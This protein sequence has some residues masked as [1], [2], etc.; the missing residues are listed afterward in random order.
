MTKRPKCLGDTKPV[1]EMSPQTLMDNG[2]RQIENGN[3]VR[4]ASPCGY[5]F[6]NPRPCRHGKHE[7]NTTYS[8]PRGSRAPGDY[9]DTHNGR[10][11]TQPHVKAKK[12]LRQNYVIEPPEYCLKER[13]KGDGKSKGKECNSSDD[14]DEYSKGKRKGKNGYYFSD[15]DDEYSKGK[16]KKGYDSDDDDCWK[17]GKGKMKGDSPPKGT[18]S[19]GGV[20]YS[21]PDGGFGYR[22][23]NGAFFERDGKGDDRYEF[24]DGHGW[25]RSKGDG[26][27]HHFSPSRS[28]SPTRC[29]SGSSH[30]D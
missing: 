14:A 21:L 27:K 12:E 9:Q 7:Y 28:D 25:T 2:F 8:A 29:S 15:D 3:F 24:P 26:M 10:G 18:G 1:A 22:H 16:G 20:R 13:N 11:F 5:E 23:D 4:G 6:A 19:K 30:D 17:K